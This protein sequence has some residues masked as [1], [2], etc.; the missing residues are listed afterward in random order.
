ML[1]APHLKPVQPTV[2]IAG[3]QELVGGDPGQGSDRGIGHEEHLRRAIGQTWISQADGFVVGARSEAAMV[4]YN[5][6]G[7][8][9]PVPYEYCIAGTSIR[10]PDADGC[11]H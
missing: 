7:N 3:Y 6:G 10:I 11:V 4:Y 1:L 5:Q 8:H 2:F 9:I